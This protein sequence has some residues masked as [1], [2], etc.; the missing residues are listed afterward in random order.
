MTRTSCKH[1]QI[2]WG[3]YCSKTSRDLMNPRQQLTY[4]DVFEEHFHVIILW[5]I[6]IDQWGCIVAL[7][8]MKKW[9]K[10]TKTDYD[11]KIYLKDIFMSSFFE[12]HIDRYGHTVAFEWM[13]KGCNSPRL[14]MEQRCACKT[15]SCCHPL[16]YGYRPM[17]AYG[18]N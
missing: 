16:K 3:Q 14:T 9:C 5:K 1:V 17:W 2:D 13:T 4:K 15:S 10:I 7:E 6:D 8:W 18:C 12:I 11:A